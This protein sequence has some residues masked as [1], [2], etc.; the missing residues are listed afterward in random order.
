M[1]PRGAERGRAEEETRRG[2]EKEGGAEVGRE[3][4]LPGLARWDTRP[5]RGGAGRAGSPRG[6]GWR[7]AVGAAR[8]CPRRDSAR[9]QPRGQGA[10]A[11]RAGG[12][13]GMSQG[14]PAA[15]SVLQ[16]SVAAPGALEVNTAWV[17]S[18]GLQEGNGRHRTVGTVL[19]VSAAESQR[20]TRGRREFSSTPSDSYPLPRPAEEPS[21]VYR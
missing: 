10:L 1:G 15:G 7:G 9:R 17:G 11:G 21:L 8:G 14:L 20:A 5:T 18:S 12:A 6:R 3:G 2:W 19:P 16:R 4:P 13:P